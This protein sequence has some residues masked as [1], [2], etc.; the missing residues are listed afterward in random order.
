MQFVVIISV[1]IGI[2]ALALSP[3]FETFQALTSVYQRPLYSRLYKSTNTSTVSP[4]L[5]LRW[6]ILFEKFTASGGKIITDGSNAF[7]GRLEEMLSGL[8]VVK[9]YRI[10][11]ITNHSD[12]NDLY[13]FEVL[14]DG[15]LPLNQ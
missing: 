11:P 15:V 1:V 13:E 4:C 14:L 9:N 5:L 12:S 8:L 10:L 2:F 6:S 3:R 7:G